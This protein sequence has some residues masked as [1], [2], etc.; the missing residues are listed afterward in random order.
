[1]RSLLYYLYARR[2]ARDVR[3]RPRPRHVGIILDG[4]RRHGR[5]HGIT[6]P[7]TLYELAADKLDAVLEWCAELAIPAGDLI[8][9]LNRQFSPPAG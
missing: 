2:L 5:A 7:R 4:N 8:C 6:E 9:L 1:M 3:K